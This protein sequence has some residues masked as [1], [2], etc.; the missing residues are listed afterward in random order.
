LLKHQ[1]KKEAFF[2]E[3]YIRPIKKGALSSPF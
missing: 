3:V 1:E 2:I